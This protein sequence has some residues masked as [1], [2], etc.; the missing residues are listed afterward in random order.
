[1][2]AAGG[3]LFNSWRIARLVGRVD[4]LE[5]TMRTVLAVTAVRNVPLARVVPI[6]ARR[7]NRTVLGSGRGSAIARKSLDRHPDP[8][9]RLG[10]PV[11]VSM[12]GCP[13]CGAERSRE[14]LVEEVFHVDDR[15]VLV[16]RIPA[17]VCVRC[18][19]QSFSRD[20]AERVRT[21]LDAARDREREQRE[22]GRL[23]GP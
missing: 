2:I 18:G 22:N 10:D 17:R 3:A 14:E 15:H 12:P 7:R 23:T 11:E 9:G 19:E 1:M 21:T 20:T 4:A 16:G 8:V 13:V 5:A 6:P